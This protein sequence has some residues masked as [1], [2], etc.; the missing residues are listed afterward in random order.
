MLSLISDTEIKF[1]I[2][3][4]I[5]SQTTSVGYVKHCIEVIQKER[6]KNVQVV[7]PEDYQEATENISKDYSY[8]IDPDDARKIWVGRTSLKT[9]ITK[10]L[11]YY[12]DR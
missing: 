11:F 9:G 4:F 6:N 10:T 3:D 5:G 8:E 1:G 2:H 7:L 12:E